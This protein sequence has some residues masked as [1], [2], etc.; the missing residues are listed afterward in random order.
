MGR[1]EYFETIIG[2]WRWHNIFMGRT[3]AAI[4][5]LWIGILAM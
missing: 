2:A 1:I 5:D 4:N 3:D